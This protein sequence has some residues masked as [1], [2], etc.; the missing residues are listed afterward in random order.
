V[1]VYPIRARAGGGIL[2]PD[3]R[4]PRPYIRHCDRVVPRLPSSRRWRTL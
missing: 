3:R 1:R 2:S 4:T